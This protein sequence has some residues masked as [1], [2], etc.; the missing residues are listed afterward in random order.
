MFRSTVSRRWPSSCTIS[1]VCLPWNAATDSNSSLEQQGI[2]WKGWQNQ[3]TVCRLSP[4]YSGSF[5][6]TVCSEHQR[7]VRDVGLKGD[8]AQFNQTFGCLCVQGHEP[9]SQRICTFGGSKKNKKNNVGASP[10]LEQGD[11]CHFCFWRHGIC[12][13]LDCDEKKR[14][15][16][17]MLLGDLKREKS[18]WFA[19]HRK[20]INPTTPGRK[21]WDAEAKKINYIGSTDHMGHL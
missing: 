17:T 2:I 11:L 12:I 14:I 20:Y 13:R 18:N 10:P 1:A 16:K 19:H 8:D 5:G 6:S 15:K 3:H 4:C 7:P 9:P 21:A